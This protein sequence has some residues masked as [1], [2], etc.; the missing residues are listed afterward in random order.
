MINKYE[1]H[2]QISNYLNFVVFP[3]GVRG[4]LIDFVRPPWG[5]SIGFRATPRTIDFL[6]KDFQNPH[7]VLESFFFSD[8][9]TAP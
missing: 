2:V 6:P 7:L 8:K 3:Q 1:E 5:W 9:L 4:Y